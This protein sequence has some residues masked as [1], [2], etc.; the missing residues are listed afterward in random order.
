MKPLKKIL[1]SKKISGKCK[2]VFLMEHRGT[3][4]EERAKTEAEANAAA[5]AEAVQ[6]DA[7]ARLSV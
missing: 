7:E 2:N 4:Q 1:E 3:G 6:A 5:A